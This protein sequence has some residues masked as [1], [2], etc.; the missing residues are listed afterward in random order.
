MRVAYKGWS[1]CNSTYSLT[2]GTNAGPLSPRARLA[3]R[4]RA[5][6]NPPTSAAEFEL[7]DSLLSDSGA[8]GLSGRD[9]VL[10]RIFGSIAEQLFLA[11]SAPSAATDTVC[12]S[13]A[14][15][16]GHH[17]AVVAALT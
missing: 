8:N 9:E 7:A 11:E 2:R 3:F 12:S 1:I 14:T 15:W 10:G 17:A 16:L 4:H 13:V 6:T 5:Q